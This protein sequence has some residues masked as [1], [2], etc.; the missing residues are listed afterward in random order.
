MDAT[1]INAGQGVHQS[2]KAES[3]WR[4]AEHGQCYCHRAKYSL[5]TCRRSARQRTRCTYGRTLWQLHPLSLWN[6]ASTVKRNDI[7][8]FINIDNRP[9]REALTWQSAASCRCPAVSDRVCTW[10]DRRQGGQRKLPSCLPCSQA[11]TAPDE[12]RLGNV[13]VP[14]IMMHERIRYCCCCT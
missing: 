10:A 14:Y 2:A 8:L 7:P 4:T 9:L 5:D 3:T 6:I 1:F 13:H 11:I 12:T